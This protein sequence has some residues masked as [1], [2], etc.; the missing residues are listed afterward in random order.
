MS[1]VRKWNYKSKVSHQSTNSFYIIFLSSSASSIYDQFMK[2]VKWVYTLFNLG[3]LKYWEAD[4]SAIL[5][6]TDRLN[7]FPFQRP[8]C[9]NDVSYAV[10]I[11]RFKLFSSQSEFNLVLTKVQL[12]AGCQGGT[13]GQDGVRAQK[14][15]PDHQLLGLKADSR[16]SPE[17]V[18][19]RASGHPPLRPHKAFRLRPR[20][21]A[22]MLRVWTAS[23]PRP[24]PHQTQLSSGTIA[25]LINH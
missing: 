24:F 21:A 25:V 3:A 14:N 6:E 19:G 8:G 18:S 15:P 20:K 5:T 9:G 7:I 22:T 13:K 16:G 10:S 4:I 1:S 17:T 12:A 23:A 11:I 2:L